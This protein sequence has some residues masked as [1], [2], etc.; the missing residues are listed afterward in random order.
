VGERS[1]AG[2]PAAQALTRSLDAANGLRATV[3][4][5]VSRLQSLVATLGRFVSLDEAELVRF[6]V[7]EG[8][9][10]ALTLLAPS[11]AP[12]VRVVRE[13]ADDLA[14]VR[15]EPGRLNQSL[16]GILR[17]ALDAV[18]AAGT[19]IVR[20]RMRDDQVL[21]EIEDDGPGIPPERLAHLFEFSFTRK[22]G[23]MQMALGLPTLKKVVDDLGGQVD[24]Q[25]SVG[26]G[27]RVSIRLPAARS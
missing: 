15:C 18:G 7:R 2:D 9:D 13:H 12:G 22:E 3:E 16:S 11:V 4:G 14:E 5:G 19:V 1:L 25:S 21:I 27:T 6:D 10:A 24:V 20:T 8:L 17:N 26:G 23:R